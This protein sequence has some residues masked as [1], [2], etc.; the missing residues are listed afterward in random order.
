VNDILNWF[1]TAK[2]APSSPVSLNERVRS[3]WAMPRY[4]QLY[5]SNDSK[6]KIKEMITDI[7]RIQ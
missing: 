6:Q 3:G 4:M 7:L 1:Y 5:S 2:M